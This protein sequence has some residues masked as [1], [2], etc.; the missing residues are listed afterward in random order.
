MC[1]GSL[2]LK[3][4]CLFLLFI[5]FAY[6]SS[7]GSALLQAAAQPGEWLWH[8]HPS[9][10]SGAFPAVWGDVFCCHG[11][12]KASLL[13]LSGIPRQLENSSYQGLWSSAH[14]V[15]VQSAWDSSNCSVWR[16][17]QS[18][19]KKHF[20]LLHVFSPAPLCEMSWLLL[21]NSCPQHEQIQSL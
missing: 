20:F 9:L 11:G 10:S 18:V 7:H 8:T 2:V 1:C 15:E 21:D 13:I 17:S 4:K 19:R 14:G 12:R 6:L 5:S 3:L 16:H